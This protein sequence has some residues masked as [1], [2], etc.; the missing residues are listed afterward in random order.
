MSS[1]FCLPHKK[2]GIII[3]LIGAD[4]R[5]E[6]TAALDLVESWFREEETMVKCRIVKERWGRGEGLLGGRGGRM[7]E[8][9][10]G[11]VRPTSLMKILVKHWTQLFKQE[12]FAQRSKP[13]SAGF[14]SSL[15]Q[16]LRQSAATL[17]LNYSY[18]QKVRKLRP[19]LRSRKTGI[20]GA[21]LDSHRLPDGLWIDVK[22][23][24][25]CNLH[26]VWAYFV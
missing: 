4:C 6:K 22:L 24:E 14:E 3:T 21:R 9:F 12:F 2:R 15:L 23:R 20:Q 18:K 1:V 5:F 7:K 19:R 25:T 10:R 11:F 26:A 13:C 16:T 17:P 8:V